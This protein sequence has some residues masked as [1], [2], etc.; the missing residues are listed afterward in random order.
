MNGERAGIASA[1]KVFDKI[2]AGDQAHQ[3]RSAKVAVA[4][5]RG[6]SMSDIADHHALQQAI[7]S[8]PRAAYID[9]S[10]GRS[11]SLNIFQMNTQELIAATR[12]VRD[13]EQGLRLMA[14]ENKEAGL[15]AHREINR[16]VHNFVAGSMSLIDHTRQFVREHYAGSAL[17][18]AYNN[19]VKVDFASEPVAKFVQNLRNYM[20]HKGLPNSQMFLHF[21]NTFNSP[22]AG[23]E[24]ST[25]V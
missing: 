18:G 10:Y 9:R 16:L 8:A 15:Q 22:G 14:L 5:V 24:L 1:Q 11:F 20:L 2:R 13:P 23:A 25:G 6:R 12:N 4:A 17:E 7:R 21:D 3:R 19:Q